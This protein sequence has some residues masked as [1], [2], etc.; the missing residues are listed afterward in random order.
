M[1]MSRK[2]LEQSCKIKFDIPIKEVTDKELEN[3]IWVS[4]H[5]KRMDF[6]KGWKFSHNVNMNCEFVLSR[7]PKI[8]RH[9]F[10]Y[11]CNKIGKMYKIIDDPCMDNIR[12]SYSKKGYYNKTYKK[13]MANGCCGFYDVE[14]YNPTTENSF[15][16]GCNYRH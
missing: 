6:P 4:D 12:I 3:A 16:L 5:F 7:L 2:E 14:I 13:A 10:V 15:W 9:D 8:T 11:M 1:V